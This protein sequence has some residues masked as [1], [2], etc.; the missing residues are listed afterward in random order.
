MNPWPGAHTEFRGERLHIWRS[1][2]DASGSDSQN[3]P[4]MLAGFSRDGIRVQCG[5]GTMLDILE[6]QKPGRSRISG[7][8]FANGAR[9]RPGE[10]IFRD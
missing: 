7:R 8:E 5:E 2:P 3:L 4:G 10:A 9:L 6:L 1:L